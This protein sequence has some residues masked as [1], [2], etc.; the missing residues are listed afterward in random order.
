M[1]ILFGLAIEALI[2]IV[3]ALGI[4]EIVDRADHVN[5]ESKGNV[6]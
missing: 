5:I 6:K 2:V 4:G 1:Q 3:I